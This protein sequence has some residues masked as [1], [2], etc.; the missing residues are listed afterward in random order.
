ML[1]GHSR[2]HLHDLLGGIIT[3][4]PEVPSELEHLNAGEATPLLPIPL[5]GYIG[6]AKMFLDLLRHYDLGVRGSLGGRV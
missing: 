4:V 5:D 1:C 6:T 2:F 3:K